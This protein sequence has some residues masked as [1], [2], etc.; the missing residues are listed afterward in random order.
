MK[1]LLSSLLAFSLTTALLGIVSCG[2]ALYHST[3]KFELAPGQTRL[4]EKDFKKIFDSA[5][6]TGMELGY[7]VTSSNMEQGI[8]SFTREVGWDHVPVN[9]NVKIRKEN[10]ESAYVDMT[11]QSPR[12][13]SNSDLIEFQNKLLPK[14]EQKE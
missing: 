3:L 12:P 14:L 5:L 1:T 13:L 2:P 9:I 7:R 4:E 6:S 8:I 10:E 11:M